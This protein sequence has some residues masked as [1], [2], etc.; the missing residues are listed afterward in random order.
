MGYQFAC[1]MQKTF[2]DINFDSN[3]LIDKELFH[4]YRKH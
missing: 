1:W 4:F 3:I 2:M